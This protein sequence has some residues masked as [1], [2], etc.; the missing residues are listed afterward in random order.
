MRN[1]QPVCTPPPPRRILDRNR[2][3]LEFP[4]P[5]D[6]I[7]LNHAGVAPWPRC[8]ARAVKAFAEE[9]AVRGPVNYGR[10]LETEARLRAQLKTLINAPS[11][12]DIALLKN[13]SEGISM[14][15]GGLDWTPGDNIVNCYEEF[16]SNRI[17]W[18]AL[19]AQGVSLRAVP[20]LADAARPEALLIAACDARTRLLAVSSVQYASGLRLDL[21]ILGSYCRS[22]GI[23]FCVDAIQ[24]LGAFP[25]DVSASNIDFVVADAHKWMLGPEGIALFYVRAELRNRLRLQQFGW[26]MTA[27]PN[28]YE[29][30]DWRPA[31][32]ARRFECGSPNLL[33]IHAFSASVGLLLDVGLDVVT[34]AL[35]ENAN[36]LCDAVSR[37]PD[38][39]LL[40][41]LAPERRSGIVTFRPRDGQVQALFHD[42]TL[43]GVICAVRSGGI[44]F[45]PHFYTSQEKLERALAMVLER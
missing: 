3:A 16:P 2:L 14:V 41:P 32:T 31:P 33:G 24:S 26:H 38:Y 28:A 39:E 20:L 19:E 44:R 15:A 22:R 4:Q 12:D 5:E 7:Y 34:E 23:L 17:A 35:A 45:S 1:N 21:G 27:E 36:I 6:L 43:G 9:N 29:R 37:D 42:L 18:Q 30:R 25:M 11:A 10:W 13:T 40:S 8:A